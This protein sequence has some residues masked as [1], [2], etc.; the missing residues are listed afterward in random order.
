M[1]EL[2]AESRSK[3]ALGEERVLARFFGQTQVTSLGDSD[4]SERAFPLELRLTA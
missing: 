4:S 1:R 2:S 3:V